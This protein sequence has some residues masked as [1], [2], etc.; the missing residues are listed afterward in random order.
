MQMNFIVLSFSTG[1]RMG[2]R[3]IDIGGLHL[4]KKSDGTDF[5][6]PADLFPEVRGGVFGGDPNGLVHVRGL[7]EEEAA[8]LLI[9]LDEGTVGGGDLPLA[10]TKERGRLRGVQGCDRNE[11]TALA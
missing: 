7:D 10:R 9:R 4:E 5:D 1:S 8:D 3:E 6:A 2:E 11:M